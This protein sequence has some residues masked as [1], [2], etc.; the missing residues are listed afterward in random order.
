MHRMTREIAPDEAHSIAPDVAA[1]EMPTRGDS[2]AV[3]DTGASDRADHAPAAPLDHATVRAIVAGIMLAMF[4]SAL[5][6][7]IV[8]PALPAIG[9]SLGNIDDLSWVVTAYLLAATA[10]TP[11]FGKL[12]DIYGRR[13]L[14]LVAIGFFIAGSVAC[15]LAPTLWLLILSRGLQGIGGGGLLP[16]AQTIIADLLSPRERPV[17]QGRTSVMF[18]SASILGPVLGGLLTDHLHWSFIFWINVPLGAIALVMTERALRQL[19]RNDRP[20]QLDIIGAALMVGAS[21]AL[22]LAL[23]WGGSHDA[24]TSWRIVSLFAS[25]AALWVLFVLRLLTAHEPFIPLAILHGRI[26][27]MIT[28]AAFFSIGTVIGV[29]IYMPLYCQAVLG[30]SASLSGL[31]LIAYMGGATLGS[32]LSTRVV[33]RVKRYLRVPLAGLVI[34]VAAL[35]VLASDPAGHSLGE[36]VG[37]LFV[38]GLGLGPMYP[39]STIVMQNVVKPHQLG[40]ATG[41]LNFFR[42]LGGAIVV[43]IFG[44]I[45]LSGVSDGPG[46][47][48]IE[49]V[50]AGHGDLAP[51][52]HWVFVAAAVCLS[53][54]FACLM[55]VEERPLHGPLRAAEQAAE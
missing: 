7:T 12:S 23:N 31:A 30:V 45:V 21:V 6:Q 29:T 14:L 46:V 11:L 32:L 16:I 34:A 1:A 24:W 49:R 10:T 43:A 38:L 51:A 19:P 37:L 53:I 47:V 4:L 5:E 52:F 9:K 20:H 54:S 2:R 3:A 44:A 22:M 26:T 13:A 48:M 35:A 40:T 55:V 41:T 15:A 39:V 42:T 17:V 28:A 18:M 8:A 50:A 33:V 27:S 25:S 36:V